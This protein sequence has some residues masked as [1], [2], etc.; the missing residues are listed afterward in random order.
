MIELLIIQYLR[1][2]QQ[3]NPLTLPFSYPRNRLGTSL[4]S[5]ILNCFDFG[6]GAIFDC[7]TA[8]MHSMALVVFDSARHPFYQKK[9]R[10]QA[11]RPHRSCA[12]AE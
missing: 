3:Y 12:G 6:A 7:A 8:A 5:F 9:P 1:L 4:K 11:S 10:R 2:I